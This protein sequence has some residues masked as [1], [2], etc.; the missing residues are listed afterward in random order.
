MITLTPL[1]MAAAQ[2][3]RLLLAAPTKSRPPSSVN[4]V[5]VATST[6]ATLDV[7][8][9]PL[10]HQSELLQ[11]VVDTTRLASTVLATA[12]A[13]PVPNLIDSGMDEVTTE[14]DLE[15]AAVRE[16]TNEGIGDDGSFAAAKA[17]HTETPK[18]WFRE[19]MVCGLALSG[20]GER[21][22]NHHLHIPDGIR[23]GYVDL[24]HV[25]L[26]RW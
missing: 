4:A 8:G 13:L 3:V 7:N 26:C 19:P 23:H 9:N 25:G 11:A 5:P 20:A 6:L 16:L 15:T 1:P 24:H 14:R 2:R 21:Y 10:T 12:E 17:M 18:T 22:A